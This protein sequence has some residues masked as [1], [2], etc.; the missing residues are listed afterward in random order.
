MEVEDCF[1]QKDLDIAISDTVV[2]KAVVIV[3]FDLIIYRCADRRR[4][5]QKD[6]QYI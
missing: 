3:T 1:T 2:V 6:L 4:Y 5:P